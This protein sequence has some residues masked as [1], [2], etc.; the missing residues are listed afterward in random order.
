M[1]SP[2]SDTK[3]RQAPDQLADRNI[4]AVTV[5]SIVITVIALIVAW[6]LFER[7]TPARRDEA[8]SPPPAPSTISTVEQ[9]LI[10]HTERGQELRTKQE[11]ALTRWEWADRD[12]GVARIPVEKAI[13]LLAASPLPVDRSVDELV[14][15]AGREAA[16]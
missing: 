13:D 11:S 15:D 9:S 14:S 4:A 2:S 8:G 16:P 12:A 5:T 3:L 6:V 10:L 7:W 1:S